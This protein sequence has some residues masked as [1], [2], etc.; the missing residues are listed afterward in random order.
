MTKATL[1]MTRL[2]KTFLMNANLTGADLTGANLTGAKLDGADFTGADLSSAILDRAHGKDVR[3]D[4]AI[5]PPGFDPTS[6]PPD[7]SGG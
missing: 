6:L 5:L 2:D 7:L 3:F 1:R 4:K